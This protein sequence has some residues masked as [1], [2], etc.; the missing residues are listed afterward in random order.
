MKSYPPILLLSVALTGCT[1]NDVYHTGLQSVSNARLHSSIH[2]DGTTRFRVHPAS[3]IAVRQAFGIAPEWLSY[4]QSGVSHVF[5]T[6]AM[7]NY[8]LLISWDETAPGAAPRATDGGHI[9][10]NLG[11]LFEPPKLAEVE[12]LTLQL[13]DSTHGL[14]HQQRLTIRPALWQSDWDSEKSMERAFYQ[15][16]LELA[17]R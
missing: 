10:I 2:S 5:P 3:S 8:E 13:V 7:P 11:G 16:A 14:V 15:F 1:L 12:T 9:G 4:A 17:G 6:A